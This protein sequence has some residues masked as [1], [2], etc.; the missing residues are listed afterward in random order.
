M[1]ISESDDGRAMARTR[2]NV[3]KVLKAVKNSAEA[4]RIIVGGTNLPESTSCVATTV[5]FSSRRSRRA[6]QDCARDVG[7]ASQ[8]SASTNTDP[9]IAI[10]AFAMEESPNHGTKIRQPYR[11]KVAVLPAPAPRGRDRRGTIYFPPSTRSGI[12]PR[13]QRGADCHQEIDGTE[14]FFDEPLCLIELCFR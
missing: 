7:G 2:Q 12:I 1:L 5:V 14:W 13:P 11:M 8:L 6:E 3:G 10:E 4:R 9:R